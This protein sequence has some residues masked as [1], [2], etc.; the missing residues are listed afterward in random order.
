MTNFEFKL[1]MWTNHELTPSYKLLTPG[2]VGCHVI[3]N[4]RDR[5]GGSLYCPQ[6]GRYQPLLEPAL[7]MII[8]H[9]QD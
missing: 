2:R 1:K 8:T 6:A 3:S 5:P 9:H 4:G 7:A